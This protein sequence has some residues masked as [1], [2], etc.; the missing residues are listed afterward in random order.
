MSGL[1]N[2]IDGLWS[3]CGDERIIVFT[4]NYKDKLDPALLRPGRMDMHIH[5]SYCTPCGLKILASNYLNVKEHSLF[6]E[7]D[8]L[9]MEVEVTPAE[10][11]EELMKNEDV[12]TTLTGLIGFLE[13]KKVMKRKHPDVEKQKEVD[14]NQKENGNKNESLDMEDKCEKKKAEPSRRKRA[15]KPKGRT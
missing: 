15:R 12:D 9:I 8:E 14:E 3:S 10:V 5:M 6:S 13:S 2:F 4:T 1:L 11:A 7:I